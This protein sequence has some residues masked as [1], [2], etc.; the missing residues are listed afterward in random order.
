KQELSEFFSTHPA[1]TKRAETLNGKLS[2]A[3]DIR[4]QCNCLPLLENINLGLPNFSKTPDKEVCIG[5][6]AREKSRSY[7][8]YPCGSKH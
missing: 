2:W 5:T 1:S 6:T 8:S 4:R 7:T 3:L